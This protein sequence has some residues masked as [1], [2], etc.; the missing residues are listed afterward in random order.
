MQSDKPIPEFLGCG[1]LLAESTELVGNI[2][3]M[4]SA[5]RARP[6]IAK[7]SGMLQPYEGRHPGA[8]SGLRLALRDTYWKETTPELARS[9]IAPPGRSR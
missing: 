2:H 5:Q 8:I 7:P 1:A 6:R 9:F 3:M 4:Q